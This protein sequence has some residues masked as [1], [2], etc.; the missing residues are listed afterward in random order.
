MFKLHYDFYNSCF[1]QLLERKDTVMAIISEEEQS[2]NRTL[3]QG[4]KYFKKVL[5]SLQNSTDSNTKIVIPAKE[6][7]ILFSSMGFPLDLTE[8]MAAERGVA[9]DSAGF[10]EL[11]EADRK[12]SEAAEAAR[13]GGGG[14]G[15]DLTMVAEQTSWLKVS[16]IPT[17]DTDAKYKSY[18]EH[19][20]Q[21]FNYTKETTYLCSQ[22]FV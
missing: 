17:T 16:G 9:V 2:F 21:V 13:R 3:D 8:L 6:A 18:I 7:H 20:T 12:I 1:A 22:N 11:M 14:T 15:R 10:N 5:S 19:E 4:V